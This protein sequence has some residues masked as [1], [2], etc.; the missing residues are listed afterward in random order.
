MREWNGVKGQNGGEEGPDLSWVVQES[1]TEE[2]AEMGSM[3]QLHSPEADA[4]FGVFGGSPPSP[5]PEDRIRFGLV[6]KHQE[7]WGVGRV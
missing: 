7:T 2:G 4:A 1:F 5:A 3:A 6:D